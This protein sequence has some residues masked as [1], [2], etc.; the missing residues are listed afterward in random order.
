MRSSL[1]NVWAGEA[2]FKIASGD[3]N[4][5]E[6]KRCESRA[7][8]YLLPRDPQAGTKLR[9]SH[10]LIAIFF[11]FVFLG[12]R[13]EARELKVATWNLGSH[14]SQ[15]EA[16]NWIELCG[17]PFLKDSQTGRWVRSENGTPGW[18]LKWGDDAPINWD[19]ANWP[20]CNVFKSGSQIVPVTIAAYE[21][22]AEQIKAFIRNTLQPDIIAFQEVSGEEAIRDVLP[23][24]GMDYFV[25]SFSDYKVGR[26]GFAWKKEL[27]PAKECVVE[28]AL[29]LPMLCSDD[30]LPPGLSLAIQIEGQLLRLLTIHLRSAF[31]TPIKPDNALHGSSKGCAILQQQIVPLERWIQIKSEDTDR[32]VV[33][34]DF[35]RNLWHEMH[36]S[37]AVRTD[38]SSPADP[39]KSSRARSQ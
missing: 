36:V 14:I 39:R 2:C 33:L 28:D 9:N 29:S 15:K 12:F 3:G 27:G 30:R 7:P 26:L 24:N 4:M 32:F 11:L 35:N 31:V 6:R 19:F 21:K 1:A 37:A 20:R 13:A 34:G 38:G 10:S 23:D 5:R 18:E 25:C 22:R 8:E 16:S 17:A